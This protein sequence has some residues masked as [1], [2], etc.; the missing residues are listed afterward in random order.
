M[1]TLYDGGKSMCASPAQLQ[2]HQNNCLTFMDKMSHS[3]TSPPLS[4]PVSSILP[5]FSGK[6]GHSSAMKL[7]KRELIVLLTCPHV[8]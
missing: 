4:T 5:L 3:S 6:K 7:V 1:S 2:P 8:P